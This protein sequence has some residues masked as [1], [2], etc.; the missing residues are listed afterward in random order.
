[1][2]YFSSP[3]SLIDDSFTDDSLA[4]SLG[5]GNIAGCNTEFFNDDTAVLSTSYPYPVLDVCSLN[6][7]LL[8]PLISWYLLEAWYVSVVDLLLTVFVT[9]V[10][11]YDTLSWYVYVD[12]FF[13]VD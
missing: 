3:T 5:A 1:M 12:I 2:K 9:D 7:Y 13:S 8:L 6:W 4:T 10:Y 11:W